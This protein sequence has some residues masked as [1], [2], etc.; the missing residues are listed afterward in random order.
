MRCRT[1]LFALLL[2]AG[3]A[4]SLTSTALAQQAPQKKGETTAGAKSRGAA[5]TDENIKKARGPNEANGAAVP[6][7]ATK[8]GAGTRGSVSVVHLD[9]WTNYVIDLYVNGEF[10]A[11]SGPWGDA[12]CLVTPGNAVLYGKATFTDGSSITWG[13]RATY[14]DGTYDWKLTP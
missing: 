6:A 10:C 7:P 8:G 1:S 4:F 11:T 13:P 9:N 3:A 5:T 12:Y 14:V 2:V